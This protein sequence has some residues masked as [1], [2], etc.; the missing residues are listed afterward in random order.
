MAVFFDAAD[1]ATR[2]LSG[3]IWQLRS[4]RQAS[5]RTAIAAPDNYAAEFKTDG[6]ISL[7]ADCNTCSGSYV[8]VAGQNP[9]AGSLSVTGLG[10]TKMMC[11]PDSKGGL[12]AAI[13]GNATGYRISG[14]TLFC[15]ANADTLVFTPKP[16]LI[17][18]DGSRA[19][20]VFSGT[21]YNVKIAGHAVTVT[22]QGDKVAAAGI[23]D[24]RGT[25]VGQ[26]SACKESVTMPVRGLARGMYLLQVTFQ[27]GRTAMAPLNL[28]K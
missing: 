7:A 27:S 16:T 19:A 3:K 26:G 10:C 8:A 21:M 23:F 22:G 13:L 9:A 4:L 12:F 20:S 1:A 2:A 28:A 18:R 24:L 17:R 5:G 15:F 11:G 25:C 6:K 14:D